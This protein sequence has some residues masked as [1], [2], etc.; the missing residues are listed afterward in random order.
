MKLFYK[1]GDCDSKVFPSSLGPG[2]RDIAVTLI[3]RVK[4]QHWHG[5]GEEEMF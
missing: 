4:A 1:G 2:S 3:L 5:S